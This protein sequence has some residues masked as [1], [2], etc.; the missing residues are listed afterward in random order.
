MFSPK[1]II[2]HRGLGPVNNSSLHF[3]ISVLRI[4]LNLETQSAAT[5]SCRELLDRSCK[6]QGFV[7]GGSACQRAFPFLL[8]LWVLTYF[9]H[10]G[11]MT[12]FRSSVWQKRLVRPLLYKLSAPMPRSP[13][14]WRS[15]QRRLLA[16]LAKS[17][18]S[19]MP[20]VLLSLMP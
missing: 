9:T 17:T 8:S 1:S 5:S 12:P 4:M 13:T 6:R 15:T 20:L 10:R 18:G 7:C 19:R 2:P 14:K 16:L 11:F 3:M